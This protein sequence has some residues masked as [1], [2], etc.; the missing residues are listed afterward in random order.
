LEKPNK[1]ALSMSDRD[2]GD[3]HYSYDVAIIGMSGRFP[4]AADL[5]AFWRNLRA[6]V[7]SITFFADE[8]LAALGVDP[9]AFR[10]PHFVKASPIIEDIDCFDA[11]FFG[12]APREA[13]LLDPQQRIFLECAVAAIEDAGYHT[14]ADIGMSGVFAGMSLST[15]LL[16]NVLTSPNFKDL[17]D[18]FQVMLS[19]D[20]DF[21]STRVSY[22]LDLKGPSID[23]QSGCST[24][25]V[26]VHL[27]CQSLLSYQCD[28]ALAGGVSVNVP[29]RTGYFYQEG[30]ICSPDGHCRAF[31][32]QAQGTLFGSGV[33]V[34]VLKR[35]DEALADR[36]QI[37]AVIKGSAIN[38]DGAL[39]VGYTAPSV[40]GQAE[41]IARAQSIAEIAPDTI[42]YV[43]THGTATALGDPME[44]TALT[45]V[46]RAGTN[47][48]GFCAIGSVK[49]NIGHLDAAAGVAG[50]IKTVLALTHQELP[51]SLHFQT[52]N[53]AIDFAS[54]PFYVNSALAPWPAGATPRRAGVSSF[55]IGG[56][57][58]HVILEEAPPIA[59]SG[60]S[61]PWQLLVLAAQTP[62]ALERATENL[63]AYLRQHPDASLADVAYT[64]QVG[65]RA[66]GY[67]RALVCRDQA[68]ALTCLETLDPQRVFSVYQDATEQPVAFMFPGGGA[69]Y[70]AMGRGLYQS[71]PSFRETID[72]C[73]E[74]LLPQLGVDLRELLYPRDEG[75]RT[76]DELEPS[77]GLRPASEQSRALTRTSL[78]LPALFAVEYAMAQLWIG[79]G[80]RPAALIG[81]SLGEYIAACI[82]GV[83]S[84]EDALALVALRG[85]LMEELPQGAMLSLALP[86]AE[87]R[88]LLGARLALAA[89]NGPAQCVVSGP[90][91]AIDAL[92]AALAEQELEFRRL[93]IDVAAHSELVAPILARFEQAV[94][95]F[96]L[97]A[98]AIPFVSNV[99]GTWISA[100]EATD[101][102]YWRRHLR[103]TV[104]FGDG[105]QTLLRE[106]QPV[107]LEVGPGQTLSTLAKLQSANTPARAVLSSIRHP[108]DR[109]PDLAFLLTTAGKLW[110]AG[111]AID[112][113]LLYAHEQRRRIALPTYPF[114][115][116]RY[117]I[118]PHKQRGDQRVR[119]RSGKLPDLA[120]WFAVPA[121][122]R[123]PHPRPKRADAPSEQRGWLVFLDDCGLGA[124]LVQ[125]LEQAGRAVVRVTA[126]PR[127]G[128]LDSNSYTIDPRRRDDYAA[129]LKELHSAGRAPGVIVHMWS[130]TLPSQGET[131]IARFQAAQDVGF[132]SLL[133]L[134]QALGVSAADAIALW[135]VAN[136]LQQVES[137]DRLC[138]EKATLLAPCKVIPQ[139]Y[140]QIT[141][142]CI[143]VG[144]PKRG[145]HQAARL[146][147]ALMNEID[148]PTADRLLAYRGDH[149]WVQTFEP[150]RLEAADAPLRPLRENGVYVITGGLGGVGML[151]AGYLARTVRAR[152]VLV[153]RTALPQRAGWAAWL[154]A[155]DETDSTSRRLRAVQA[156]EALGAEVL[157]IRADVAAEDQMRAAVAQTIAHFGALHGLIHAAGIAGEKAV[158][159]IPDTDRAGCEAFFRPKVDGV[160]AINAALAEHELDFCLLISSN[161][162]ILG[163]LG[164]TAYAAANLFMDAFAVSR[165]ADDRR[166][167]ISANWDGWLSQQN[168]TL[169]AT[170]QT[171]MD[172]Y[173]M[174]PDESV[175]AFARVVSDAPIGQLVVSTG[176]LAA[177]LDLWIRRVALDGPAGG[178]IAGAASLHPRPA[179][180]T[181]YTPPTNEIEQIIVAI[182]QTLL[183]IEQLGI[184]DNFFDLG[185]NSL[186]GLKVIARLKQEL[187][188]D[189]PVVALFEGPTVS[190]LARMIGQRSPEQPGYAQRRSR[191]ERRREKAQDKHNAEAL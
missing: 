107:L 149:R 44:L 99:S 178:P 31:D 5:D 173:A 190:A 98:P 27:A 95:R 125:Q 6:G 139:E 186:I 183:G 76:N 70:I 32:A 82:A 8:E 97:H 129:L 187:Q 66:F 13:E 19:N 10:A 58:A 121:W 171:S 159:L 96:R 148:T 111:V 62:T 79:W 37:Y 3:S 36:D 57:N 64:L 34:V 132:Y 181:A 168:D 54:T 30:G 20:K 179:L 45:Q 134:A 188:I 127:F 123:V 138:P 25:L 65:R 69:Q 53:P 100:D 104:Q 51:P 128:V 152:L 162:A 1:K 131:T 108:Y 151:I 63:A 191:G 59:Q 143:D 113:P 153:G 112:W 167:W 124:A 22:H 39:K 184:H 21:L 35:L 166:S 7:E 93:Q 38:N 120:D 156:L 150:L 18:S 68:D 180:G 81:H 174:A 26:A 49:T 67:R 78:A 126:G 109:Q 122:K 33:G 11:A 176:D 157:L 146:I 50:L 114:E 46:F 84:L 161:A 43:E 14:A 175:E 89:I 135:V 117:W 145:S 182:W 12:Y 74:L 71:E 102:A 137:A 136:N 23:V 55:G 24:S 158:M 56:T 40:A 17:E 155:H 103:E 147:S 118:T 141:C 116:Q 75:R 42:S 115:R 90:S 165:S 106:L 83:F 169:A 16:F 177:R 80:V 142:R 61:R 15:Y 88:P 86:E 163:G 172:Q 110:L 160:Y 9:A 2:E 185:G 73:A 189:I 85:R 94:R 154:A 41:V 133:F 48:R 130:I 170:F 4:G 47:R 101:P 28:L 105:L 119:A 29:Q 52:P 144:V 87:V 164:A 60:A 91:D 77:S 72:E 92:A 140:E